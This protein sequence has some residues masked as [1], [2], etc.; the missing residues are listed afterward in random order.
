MNALISSPPADRRA[1]F[2]LAIGAVAVGASPIFLRLGELGPFAAAF[3]R[4]FLA[5]PAIGVWLLIAGRGRMERPK[6]PRDAGLMALAGFFF[7]GDLAF[8][9]LSL[10]ATSV[11]NATLFANTAP[12]FVVLIGWCAFRRKVTGI[13]LI[14][15][16]LALAG[17]VCLVQSSLSFDP[18]QLEGDAYGVVTALF[19]AGYLL[20]LERLRRS[21][22]AAVIMF[23]STAATA[24]CLLVPALVFEGQLFARSAEGWLLLLALA[25]VSQAA[26]QGL[27]AY[28]MAALP[29]S[30]TAVGLLLEPVA[31]A[32]FAGVV[33]LEGIGPWQAVGGIVVLAGIAFARLGAI[34]DKKNS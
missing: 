24:L 22:G 21:Y 14:G 28:A 11:A 16:G 8:W 30:V 12:V 31:A 2:A 13:F 25:W 15:L 34:N 26:G 27:I 6:T 19:L 20:T 9:H 3:H 7:A 32:L 1:L 29:A 18:A 33:L 5:L 10:F 17:A 4:A 23:W